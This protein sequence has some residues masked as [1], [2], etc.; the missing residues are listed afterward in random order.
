MAGF[1]KWCHSFKARA[2]SGRNEHHSSTKNTD[3]NSDIVIYRLLYPLAKLAAKKAVSANGSDIRGKQS[4]IYF[5]LCETISPDEPP[6]PA[7]INELILA[8]SHILAR[9]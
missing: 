8:R 5:D 3:V 1:S 6:V 2:R 4:A 9:K 7:E